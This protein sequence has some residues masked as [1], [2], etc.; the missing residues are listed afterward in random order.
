[1]DF[2]ARNDGRNARTTCLHAGQQVQGP[3]A[4]RGI[5]ETGLVCS[6]RSERVDGSRTPRRYGGGEQ[7]RHR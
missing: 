3:F 5:R 7:R 4:D 2:T 6:K 1:M